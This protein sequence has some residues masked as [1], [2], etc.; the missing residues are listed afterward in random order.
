[1]R[2]IWIATAVLAIA[3]LALAQQAVWH[4]EKGD[5]VVIVQGGMAP[6]VQP[7][8]E[9]LMITQFDGKPVKGAPYSAE[10]V[11][12]TIQSL[13]D[14]NRIV[15]KSSAK[16][17]RDSEGRTRTETVLQP[18]GPWVADGKSVSITTIYDPVSGEHITLHNDSKTA[19]KAI[20]RVVIH[21]EEG[22]AGAETKTVETEV[23]RDMKFNVRVPSPQGAEGGQGDVFFQGPAVMHMRHEAPAAGL[24]FIPEGAVEKTS[25]GKRVIEGVECEGTK[26]VA[27]IAAGK[28]GNDRDI[29]IVTERWHSP[30]LQMDVLRKH[31]D[32]RFGETTY[33]VNGLVRGEQSRTLFEVPAG[34]EMHEMG[35][36][37]DLKGERKQR[38]VRVTVERQEPQIF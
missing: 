9:R 35:G 23:K 5:D 18:L 24:A 36:T 12:E 33:R 29:Q 7:G 10:A 2:I 4:Q 25:L 27:T 22:P 31:T 28:I 37:V 8:G 16:M 1:M 13:V 14:G 21:K 11:T 15:N 19:M 38:E 30:E 34:Y 20:T 26:E 32:P 17:F 6:G 3:S